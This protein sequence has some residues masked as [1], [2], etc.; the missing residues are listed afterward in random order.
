MTIAPIIDAVSLL[1]ELGA[2]LAER[3][4]PALSE[5]AFVTR[6]RLVILLERIEATSAEDDE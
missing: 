4:D 6:D 1:A 2:I 3:G 5:R